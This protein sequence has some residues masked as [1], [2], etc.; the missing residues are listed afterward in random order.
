MPRMTQAP[1]AM[2]AAL[3]TPPKPLPGR[4]GRVLVGRTGIATRPTTDAALM[5]A[6]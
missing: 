6:C 1:R 5:G 3:R 4:A 2:I